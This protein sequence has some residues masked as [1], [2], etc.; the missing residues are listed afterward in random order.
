MR[1]FLV[2]FAV[3]AALV[4]VPVAA[5]DGLYQTQKYP[6]APVAAAEH[7][8]GFI[9][10]VHANGAIVYAHEQYVLRG[11]FP[12]TTYN[13]NIHVSAPADTTCALPILTGVTATF[14]TN[15][16]GNGTAYHVFTPTDVGP[17]RGATVHVYWTIT[18]GATLAYTT[19]CETIQLD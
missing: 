2:G 13:V 6:F 14:M 7:G 17:L 16:A 5:G 15:P 11:A 1:R 9:V 4:I 8:G 18:T 19:P 10:N 12:E 3:A